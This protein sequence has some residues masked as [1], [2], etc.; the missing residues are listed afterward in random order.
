MVI[1]HIEELSTAIVFYIRIHP[2]GYFHIYPN[3][4]RTLVAKALEAKGAIEGDFSKFN[5][6]M[7]FIDEY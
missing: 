5:E 3:E 2:Y 1:K 6:G 4:A 7:F